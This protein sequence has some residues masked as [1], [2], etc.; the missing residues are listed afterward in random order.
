MTN[1]AP[2][3]AEPSSVGR[4]IV[5]WG[6]SGSG[7]TTVGRRIGEFITLPVIELDALFH[8][9]NWKPTAAN[10]FRQKVISEMTDHSDG[11][12]CDGNYGIVRD[13]ILPRAD[14]VVWLRLPFR[15]I[16]WRLLKRTIGR[17]WSKELLWGTNRESFRKSFLS[18]DSILL[19]GITDW[20]PHVR[21]ANRALEEIPHRAGVIKLRSTTEVDDLLRSLQIPTRLERAAR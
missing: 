13:I 14:T 11:W 17:F 10:E 21:N 18:R 15:V 20:K 12:V 16:Y 5:V 9:P 6:H 2:A 4:H 1:P 8:G 7:K 19:W 3:S